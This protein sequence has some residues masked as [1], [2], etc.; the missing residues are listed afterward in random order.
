M[1]GKALRPVLLCALFTAVSCLFCQAAGTAVYAGPGFYEDEFEDGVEA[2]GSSPRSGEA[3][4][5]HDNS[6]KKI[7]LTFDDGPHPEYTEKILG[8]LAENEIKATF[9][10]IGEN[11]SRRPELVKRIAEAGHEI[12]NHTWSHRKTWKLDYGALLDELNRTED[13]IF[14]ACG[15]RPSLFRPPDGIR[16]AAM[17]TAAE[18]MDYKVILWTVDTRDWERKTTKSIMTCTI[19]NN[20]RSG[21]I[22]L[23]HDFVSRSDSVT[24]GALA[25]AIPKLIAEGYDFVTVSELLDSE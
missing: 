10:M 16:S 15:M 21:S 17:A 23:C 11:V 20:V 24:A 6:L 14:E 8:V 18:Q 3:I 7:A 13:A 22:I 19:L 25:E 5:S 9:F 1:R 4:K 2:G 12:G